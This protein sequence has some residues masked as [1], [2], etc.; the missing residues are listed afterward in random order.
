M[1]PIKYIVEND[2]DALWGLSVCSVGFEEIA[3]GAAYPTQ[4]HELGYYFST[5]RGRILQE[6]QLV[7]IPQGKGIL[8][9]RSAGTLEL[10]AGSM[11]LLFPGEW[12]TYQPDVEVGWKQYWIGFKG[13]N[14]DNRVDHQFLNKAKPLFRVGC[15]EEIV[16]LYLQAIDIAHQEA[17]YFQQMLA[18]ITN[19]LLGLM[20]SLDK[21]NRFNKNQEVV[22]LINRARICMREEME[23]KA[24]VQEIAARIGMGYSLFRKQFKEYTGLSPA[25]YFQEIKLQRAKELLHTSPLSVKEI[26]YLLN[27]ES[28]DYF[29]AQF[30]KKT[31]RKPTEFRNE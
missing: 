25:Q 11:F 15:N 1:K 19:Y 20:Y 12:H 16:R 26:A 13:I 28:P 18:G 24:S 31:G 2:R 4:E 10:E 23:S 5:E 3:P 29:S 8:T 30:K 9:T 21:N 22:E 6:Y 17:A 14:V 27:F 7:Y